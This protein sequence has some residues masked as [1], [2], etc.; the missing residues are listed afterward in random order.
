MDGDRAGDQ[1]AVGHGH[2]ADGPVAA[3]DDPGTTKRHGPAA[4]QAAFSAAKS[5]RPT[6]TFPLCGQ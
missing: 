4:G 5:S 3:R 2:V 1:R 6:I